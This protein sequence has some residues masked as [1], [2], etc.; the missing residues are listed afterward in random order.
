MITTL[1]GDAAAAVSA[2]PPLAGNGTG[3]FVDESS[4]HLPHAATNARLKIS[5]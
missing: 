1:G 3:F 5:R 4:E 2:G